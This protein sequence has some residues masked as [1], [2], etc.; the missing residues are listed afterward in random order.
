M[1]D[2]LVDIP[3]P[4]G[5]MN[6]FVAKP[7]QPGRHP[8]V[9]FYMDAFGVRE[10]LYEMAR[11][12]ASLGYMAVLPN[13]YY[14]KTRHFEMPPGEAGMAAMFAMMGHL[15]NAAAVSDTAA[16]L[17]YVDGSPFA[18]A[19]RIGEVGYCMSGPFVIAAA[20]RYPRRIQCIA[21]IHGANLVTD[22]ADSPHRL[23]ESLECESYVACAEVDKWA[24]P[25]DI[26]ALEAGLARSGSTYDIEWYAGARHGFVF[27]QRAGAYSQAGADQHWDRLESLFDRCLRR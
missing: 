27:P 15:D 18:D 17:E 1:T 2:F 22:N 20:A 14:R 6:T 7:N 23:A 12:I 5:L 3:T 26:A 10:E 4:H 8:V 9:L 19:S 21:V 25:A 11:R 13:L 16:L 24:S